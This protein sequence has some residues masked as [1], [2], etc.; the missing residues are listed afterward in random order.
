M[1]RP[2]TLGQRRSASWR[3][4]ERR[5]RIRC[6]WILL[7]DCR[8]ERLAKGPHSGASASGPP[9]SRPTMSRSGV[10]PRSAATSTPRS[11]APCTRCRPATSAGRSAPGPIGR[12]SASTTAPSASRS[13]PGCR[14]AGGP[15]TAATPGREDGLRPARCRE[16]RPLG[17]AAWRCGRQFARALVAGELPWTR[18]PQVYALPGLVRRYGARGS[19]RR[20]RRRSPP[21]CS[22]S[23]AWPACSSSPRPPRTGRILPL[24]GYLRPVTHYALPRPTREEGDPAARFPQ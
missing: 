8:Q 19:M 3:G 14:P 7:E 18:M 21:R 2:G 13:T 20:A 5:C 17:G 1:P 9:R 23:G 4:N 6:P 22:A 10:T 12:R 11:P 15:P 16:P 24:P